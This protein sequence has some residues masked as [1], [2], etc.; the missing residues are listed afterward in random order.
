[1]KEVGT[2]NTDLVAGVYD[3]VLTKGEIQ[4]V[5]SKQDRIT[6]DLLSYD[7][8]TVE[9]E[10]Y[11]KIA[12]AG[13][14]PVYQTY[15]EVMEKSISDVVLGNMEVE[16]IT[17]ENQ[18][19]AILIG[20]PASIENIRVL[21]LGADGGKLRSDVYLKCTAQTSLSCG[22]RQEILAEGSLLHV[23]DYLSDTAQ[24]GDSVKQMTN[25]AEDADSPAA[26]PAAIQRNPSL[27]LSPD[28]A[29]GQIIIC[30]ETGN[31]LSNG[32]YGTMEIRRYEEG[33]TLVNQLP[34]ETY[35]C[36]VVPSEMPSNYEPEALKAQAIC[37]R[38]YAYIQ[39]LQADL[40]AYGAHINDSTSYQVYNKI[41][42]TDQSVTA[43]YETAGKIL[44]YQE[45]VIEAFYFSTSMGYTDTAEIWNV[46]DEAEYGYL[47]QVCLNTSS[48]E[49]K[50]S[51]EAAFLEYITKPATGYDSDIKY[52]RWTA[53]ADYSQKSDVI[54]DILES[55]R[56]V[57][58][59][60]I[61]YYNSKQTKLLDSMKGMGALKS[62]SAA[63]RS[64][65]GAILTLKLTYQKGIVL[66]KNEYNIR[67]ILG[68]GVTEIT[69]Q[70]G[71]KAT[72]VSMLPSSFCA[73]TSQADGSMLIHGGGY[74]H[75]LG[76]SQNGANGM[77]KSGMKCED[78]LQYFYNNIKIEQME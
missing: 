50:L 44:T 47:K 38:S 74:G 13:K 53:E 17:G 46:E 72:D 42:P 1:E 12:H 51:D 54:R 52:Y 67:K 75:G 25:V 78:I 45:D 39:L 29:E 9:I 22:E 71:S 15:G 68:C 58:D 26:T 64:D 19:C 65:A 34:L 37:A 7:D 60:N 21:L 6:G 36:A 69:Y 3:F 2:V 5:R 33:Y 70:D 63:E 48:T 16:Y 77:A 23:T 49:R 57:L 41:A 30:D 56:A 66:V 18:V 40:R 43:V 59:K 32:Y 27:I 10:G 76:M 28:T 73:L 20:Q 4:R 62:I 61:Q 31:A 8:E 24:S 14:I 55:R 35:L 11:G